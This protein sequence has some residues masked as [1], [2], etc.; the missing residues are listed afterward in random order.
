ME[1]F[2]PMIQK[3]LVVHSLKELWHE[4]KKT[5]SPNTKLSR[6]SVALL[7]PKPLKAEL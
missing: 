4:G 7:L 2:A 6:V 5:Y 3:V 1:Q